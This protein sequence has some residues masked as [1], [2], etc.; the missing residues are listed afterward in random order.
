MTTLSVIIPAYNNLTDVLA[1]LN[2]LRA[3][4]V[5]ECE[6][7]VQD[8]ASPA[9]HLPMLIPQEVASVQRN[10]ENVGFGVNCNTGAARAG[11]DVLFFINQDC[12]GWPGWSN[13]WDAALRSAFND[14]S[15]GI[16]GARLLF[17][18]TNAI[19]SAGGILDA[20]CQPHHR[21]LGYN[22]HHPDVAAACDVTWVT[23]AALAIRRD[24]F[25]AVNG[26]DAAYRAYFEDV[27]LCLKVRA[28]GHRVRYEPACTLFHKV[29]T[30]GGS[31]HFMNS[32]RTFKE[33]WVD[34]GKVQQDSY[35]VSE[36]W[37]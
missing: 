27:D 30:T 7:V 29:G 8:D 4:R 35:V 20:H 19:Q 16:V 15:V 22:P 12:F 21:H 23:G 31:P 6:F 33:R 9:V 24:L 17:P 3:L 18:E 34:S 11:G 5:G 13:G 1:C 2:S 10:D 36:Q 14:P 26:F 37:W 32:A 28:L 25:F